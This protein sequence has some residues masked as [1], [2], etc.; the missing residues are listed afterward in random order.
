MLCELLRDTTTDIGWIRIVEKQLIVGA[1]PLGDN[2]F[3]FDVMHETWARDED[4]SGMGK[5]EW[6]L[7]ETEMVGDIEV[8]DALVEYAV[9]R[10]SRFDKVSES[11]KEM[12]EKILSGAVALPLSRMRRGVEQAARDE[13]EVI[14]ERNMIQLLRELVATGLG[15]S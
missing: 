1:I 13:Q 4:S 3:F 8:P 7:H 14:T 12:A 10:Y 15:R 5:P 9:C 2:R 6:F 11:I